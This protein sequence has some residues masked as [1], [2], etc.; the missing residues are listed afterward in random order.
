MIK[1]SDEPTIKKTADELMEVSEDSVK[2]LGN[3]YDQK[4]IEKDSAK[5]ILQ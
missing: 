3:A 1:S 5:G 4:V 2:V